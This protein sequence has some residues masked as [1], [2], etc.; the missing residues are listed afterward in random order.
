MAELVLDACQVAQ[1]RVRARYRPV[2][3]PRQTALPSRSARGCIGSSRNQ[4]APQRR[5]PALLDPR[6]FK[7]NNACSGT[8][9]SVRAEV[10]VIRIRPIEQA[11]VRIA[12][13]TLSSSDTRFACSRG[14][15]S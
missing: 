5:E 4:G 2:R 9:A 10:E 12:L 14:K 8:V 1:G 6:I 3:A 13:Q 7:K 15:W 11:Q